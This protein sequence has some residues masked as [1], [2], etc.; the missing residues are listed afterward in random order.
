MLYVL[1]YE[2]VNV[3]LVSEAGV[4]G[5]WNIELEVDN[6]FMLVER[7]CY[8]FGIQYFTYDKVFDSVHYQICV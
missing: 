3:E 8:S 5:Y 2:C 1:V 6:V 4:A 7:R